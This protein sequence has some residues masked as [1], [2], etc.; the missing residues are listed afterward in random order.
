MKCKKLT[1]E[2]DGTTNRTIIKVDGEQLGLVQRIEFSS[3]MHDQFARIHIEKAV[4]DENT[5]KI[6]TKNV[7]GK[8]KSVIEILNLEFERE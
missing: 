5:K 3:E 1:I 7:A 2:T 8:E 4:W 6:M